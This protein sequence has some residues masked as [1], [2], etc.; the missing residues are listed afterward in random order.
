MRKRAVLLLLIIGV[1]FSLGVVGFALDE[2]TELEEYQAVVNR[3]NAK[4]GTAIELYGCPPN[5]T[6]EEFERALINSAQ[7]SNFTK[8]QIQ[9]IKSSAEIY[10]DED[11]MKCLYWH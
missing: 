10:G 2:T 1:C 8:Q 11:E 4:F 9:S 6:V 5:M 7:R 3:V